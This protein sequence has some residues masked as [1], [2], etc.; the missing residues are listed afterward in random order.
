MSQDLPDSA[1]WHTAVH[2]TIH[3]D[4]GVSIDRRR[5]GNQGEAAAGWSAW[6]PAWAL[7][8]RLM[9]MDPR[10][11]LRAPVVACRLVVLTAHQPEQGKK[12]DQGEGRGFTA[13]LSIHVHGWPCWISRTLRRIQAE[14]D[15]HRQCAKQAVV[16][17]PCQVVAVEA[18][19]M[20]IGALGTVVHPPGLN[21]P[22]WLAA[23]S[24]HRP[25]GFV[26]LLSSI[27]IRCMMLP[28][29]VSRLDPGRRYNYGF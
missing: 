19:N 4:V 9:Q 10:H 6:W 7:R 1:S 8:L 21:W 17:L 20:R 15:T 25:L 3:R 12:E 13:S 28:A 11:G 24:P 29:S 22:N 27:G 26:V 18:T 14:G 5:A 2:E 23:G 16:E